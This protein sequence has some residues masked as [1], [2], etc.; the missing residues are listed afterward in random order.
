MKLDGCREAY[1]LG[2]IHAS[3][4]KVHFHMIQGEHNEALSLMNEAMRNLVSEVNKLF[5]TK[6]ESKGEAPHV[7]V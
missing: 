6:E 7:N 1:L 5:Y 3:M 2:V 4:A